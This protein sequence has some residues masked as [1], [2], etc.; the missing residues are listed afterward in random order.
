MNEKIGMT[1]WIII[2]VGI[3]GTGILT[4]ILKLLALIKYIF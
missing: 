2:I 3:L 4:A 1:L